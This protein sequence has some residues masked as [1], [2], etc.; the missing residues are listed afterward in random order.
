MRTMVASRAACR[1]QT[2]T[3][4]G[5]A[6]LTPHPINTAPPPRLNLEMACTILRAPTTAATSTPRPI[7]C[8]QVSIAHPPGQPPVRPTRFTSHAIHVPRDSR[9][10]RF[11]SQAIHVTRDSR[12]TR[13]PTEPRSVIETIEALLND[14]CGADSMDEQRARLKE[15]RAAGALDGPRPPSAPNSMIRS[16]RSS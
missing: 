6:T 4:S 13:S 16:T 12:H 3:H 5:P 14:A 9:P 7:L 10:T 11:T 1:S 8:K 2:L 15:F